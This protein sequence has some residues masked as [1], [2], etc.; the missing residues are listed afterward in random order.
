MSAQPDLIAQLARHIRDDFARR[1]LGPVQVHADAWASLNGR[2]ARRLIDPDVDLAAV[3]DGLAPARW[4]LPA[5][6]E[7][8][9]ARRG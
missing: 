7:P 3:D 5:P 2:R 6:A 9:P 8:A 4:I 1:G